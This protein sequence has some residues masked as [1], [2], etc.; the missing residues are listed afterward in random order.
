MMRPRR[1]STIRTLSLLAWAATASAECAWVL[2][3][4][5]IPPN[6]WQIVGAWTTPEACEAQRVAAYTRSK[7]AVPAPGVTLEIPR[8]N[9]G[10][11]NVRWVCLPDTV[12][13]RAPRTR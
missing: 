6:E 5:T 1:A 9:A 12:D 11:L 8:V 7:L 10:P 4:E 13:P 2:W 3:W